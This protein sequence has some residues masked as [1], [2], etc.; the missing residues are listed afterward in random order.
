MSDSTYSE[1]GMQGVAAHQHA[2]P[3]NFTADA[4]DEM[5]SLLARIIKRDIVPNLVTANRI[6]GNGSETTPARAEADWQD[7]GFNAG[8]G[9][10]DM[11]FSSGHIRMA[12][13]ARF[14]RLLRG[15]G[16]D[17]APAMV[18][19]LVARGIPHTELYLD[20]LAPAARL[21]G[22]MWSDDECSFSDV[23]MVVARLHQILNGLRCERFGAP[24]PRN[25]PSVLLSSAPGDQHSFSIAIVDAVFQAA[26]WQTRLSH[27]N[28]ADELLDQL[29]SEHFDAVGLSVNSDGI[30]DVLRATILRIRAMSANKGIIVL[31]GG[32]AFHNAPAL[33]AHVGADALVGAGT[34]AAAKVK[35]LLP[36]HHA[37]DV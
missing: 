35:D 25:A 11:R 27:T 3:A 24:E 20:L 33:L 16:A 17:A 36:Q 29:G 18:E 14:V 21:V 26:G 37:L 10:R 5:L 12:D 31:V 30:A 23:T 15:T 32:A 9:E 28:D 4:H 22:D 1:A 7:G 13:V 6:I 34:D 19:V 8:R 2:A